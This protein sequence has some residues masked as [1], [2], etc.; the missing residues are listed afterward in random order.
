MQFLGEVALDITKAP[1]QI[2]MDKFNAVNAMNL[3]IDDWIFGEP[4]SSTIN[5]YNTVVTLSPKVTSQWFA[6]FKM[7][8]NRMSIETILDNDLVSVPRGSATQLSDVITDLNTLYGLNIQPEDYF[9]TPLSVIDPDDPDAEVPVTFSC[10]PGSFLFYGSYQLVLNRVVPVTDPVTADTADI[11]IVVDQPFESVDVSTVICNGSD[12]QAIANFRFL[13]NVATKTYISITEMIRLKNNDIALLGAFQFSSDFSGSTQSY[14][15]NCI[16]ISPSGVVK[17]AQNNLFAAN[18]SNCKRSYAH[19]SDWVYIV[20]PGNSRSTNFGVYRCDQNGEFDTGFAMPGLSYDTDKLFATKEGKF[21]TVSAVY[22][23]Y[24]DI[25]N[26]PGT[27]AVLVPQIRIDRWLVTG[28]IDP[29]WTRTII[30]ATGGNTP[31]PVIQVEQNY[32]ANVPNG[33]YI[34]F[35]PFDVPNSQGNVPVINGVDMI[36]GGEPVYGFLPVAK[37]LQ[38]GLID[39]SYNPRQVS[40][41]PEAVFDHALGDLENNCLASTDQGCVFMTSIKNPITGYHQRLPLYFDADGGLVRLSGDEYVNTYRW[42][43]KAK[44]FALSSGNFV[45]Y[46]NARLFDPAGGWQAPRD[47]VVT[48]QKDARALG[49]IHAVG[50]SL[51]GQRTIRAIAIAEA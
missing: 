30:R 27:P 36:P 2:L 38:N 21:Y 33:V 28:V 47:I 4:E 42:T 48:Y 29:S 10:K 9:D 3:S 6:S 45:A 41:S 26:N 44:I 18:I 1:E 20:D 23:D 22:N 34:A 39:S 17:K 35:E 14:N 5:G 46:G 12:G 32:A 7:Y 50:L 19:G 16:V 31:W 13:R 49:I 25:D 37:L 40:Y 51:L 24:W 15:V 8:Y 43:T 11:Y